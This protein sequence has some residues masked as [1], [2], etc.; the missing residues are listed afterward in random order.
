VAPR[1]NP[2]ELLEPVLPG[3]QAGWHREARRSTDLPAEGLPER[4]LSVREVGA[5][6]GVSTATVYALAHSSDLPFVRIRGAIRVRPEDLEA[7]R[8][9]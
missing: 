5:L 2:A 1:G 6:L 3:N 8:R 9:R 7:Y 4:L